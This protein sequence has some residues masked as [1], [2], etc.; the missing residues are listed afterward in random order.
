MWG[1]RFH[2]LDADYRGA[3]RFARCKIGGFSWGQT[4][5]TE[6]LEVKG[7]ARAEGFGLISGVWRAHRRLPVFLLC[8][9]TKGAR[10]PHHRKQ[11]LA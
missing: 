6:A 1:A 11:S 8:K 9:K 4:W 5:G 10:R 2:V 7:R 3:D